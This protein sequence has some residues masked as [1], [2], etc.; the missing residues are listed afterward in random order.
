MFDSWSIQTK[1][2]KQT[3]RIVEE[4]FKLK[5]R[6]KCIEVLRQWKY[7]AE[8][9]K[10]DK[11]NEQLAI[12]FYLRHLMV[13]IIDEWRGY[14]TSRALKHYNDQSMIENFTKTKSKLVTTRIF[15]IWKRKTNDLMSE[16]QKEQKA[17]EFYNRKLATKLLMAWRVYFKFCIRKKLLQNQA[18]WFFEMRLKTEF[19][20][21]W[22][23]KY[24]DE[25]NQRE[26]NE[27]ALFLWSIN[28][29]KN[30][31]NAWLEWH[32]EKS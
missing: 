15:L 11:N 30:C 6:D 8:Q 9:S 17:I 16:D 21:K 28:I 26:K 1:D 13:K 14:T 3:N 22:C 18:K 25:Y 19:Y 2:F 31:L 32:R 24:Q 4:M 23:V 29:Q 27:K 10:L 7:E 20:F 5:K 12:T